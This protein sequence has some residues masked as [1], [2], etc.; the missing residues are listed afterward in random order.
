MHQGL[1]ERRVGSSGHAK[2]AAVI[3]GHYGVSFLTLLTD[4]SSADC[5]T[6]LVPLY[7]ITIIYGVFTAKV[8][9]RV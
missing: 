9:G 4:D 5:A 7:I 3:A 8:A 6:V 1:E 2:L